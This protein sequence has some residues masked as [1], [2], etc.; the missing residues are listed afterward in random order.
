[1]A[2][3]VWQAKHGRQ[4]HG[5]RRMAGNARQATHCMTARHELQS[6][7]CGKQQRSTCIEHQVK[8]LPCKGSL[9]H[10][11]ECRPCSIII[12]LLLLCLFWLQSC[13]HCPHFAV[14]LHCAYRPQVKHQAK[15]QVHEEKSF[16]CWQLTG[17]VTI[18]TVDA[19]KFWC[20]CSAKHCQH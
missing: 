5:R 12:L 7:A 14:H 20:A 8:E 16:Y 11:W 1:M 15:Y 3:S 4:E 19:D 18:Y 10:Q 9:C 2:S 17:P 13:N 6:N